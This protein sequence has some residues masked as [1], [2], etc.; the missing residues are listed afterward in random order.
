M[1]GI[2]Q[3]ITLTYDADDAID[4]TQA[5][6]ASQNTLIASLD[7]V[8]KSGVKL[9]KF[10]N[11]VQKTFTALDEQGNKV[12]R[13]FQ[14]LKNNI[15]ALVSETVDKTKQLNK[16]LSLSQTNAGL[17]KTSILAAGISATR[18]GGISLLDNR[19]AG[20][21]ISLAKAAEEGNVDV[22]RLKIIY[23]S[24]SN[25][26]ALNFNAAEA[27]VVKAVNAI[28]K[29]QRKLE[30]EAQRTA[31]VTKAPGT[32][33]SFRSDQNLNAGFK[34]APRERVEKLN[35][36]LA[37]LQGIVAK[38]GISV[39]DLNR[40]YGQLQTGMVIA[41][42][43]SERRVIPALRNV[44]KAHQ[45]LH[46][47]V[48]RFLS[49]IRLSW[50][51][52]GRL[53]A[54]QIFHR[55]I[56][57]IVQEFLL[58][59]TAALKFANS[60][61]LI[62][63]LT[64]EN[65]SSTKQWQAAIRKSSE[66]YGTELLD[67]SAAY[68]EAISNQITGTISATERFVNVSLRLAAVTQST[69]QDSGAIIAGVL[70][71][72]NLDA[73]QAERV[74]AVLFKTIDLGSLNIK[75][76]SQQIG[77]AAPL[78]KILGVTF[79]ELAASIATFTIE[80]RKG[81]AALTLFRN[82][83]LK[84]IKPTE[85]M[86]V[87]LKELGFNSGPAAVKMLG[88]E[89]VI[90]EFAKVLREEGI[91]ELAKYNNELRALEGA[92]SLAGTSFTKYINALR[93]M[94]NATRDFNAA[95]EL[96]FE[97]PLKKLEIEFQRIRNFFIIDLS[98]T[99]LNALART[100]EAIG[101][102][103]SQIRG[104]TQDLS[105]SI[106]VQLPKQI[107]SILSSLFGAEQSFS[108]LRRAI[109]SAT[110]SLIIIKSTLYFLPGV[111]GKI[112]AGILTITNV[113]YRLF[114]FVTD[115]SE[116]IISEFDKI[117]DKIVE[118]RKKAA[119]ANFDLIAAS[120]EKLISDAKSAILNYLQSLE[121]A[122]DKERRIII[123]DAKDVEAFIESS[124]KERANRFRDYLDEIQRRIKANQEAI[125]QSEKELRDIINERES[126]QFKFLQQFRSDSAKFNAIVAR[127]GS[128]RNK[129]LNADP[130]VAKD[131]KQEAN[132][133][134]QE[135]N[136][137]ASKGDIKNRTKLALIERQ[138]LGILNVYEESI[139]RQNALRER[140]I[141][142][143]QT[144][145]R[146]DEQ[147]LIEVRAIIREGLKFKLFDNAGNLE[148]KTPTEAIDK[149]N[150][151]IIKIDTAINDSP[152]GQIGDLVDLRKSLTEDK[153]E[154]GRNIKLQAALVDKI[155]TIFNRKAVG[156]LVPDELVEVFK[157][158]GITGDNIGQLRL[159]AE[160][161]LTGLRDKFRDV[162]DRA[163]DAESKRIELTSRTSGIEAQ[164]L[165][166][167]KNIAS[168]PQKRIAETQLLGIADVK[169]LSDLDS[170]LKLVKETLEKNKGFLNISDDNINTFDTL[171]EKLREALLSTEEAT[172]TKDALQAFLKSVDGLGEFKNAIITAQD[173]SEIA[174][175]NLT[176][177]IYK[178]ID[179]LNNNGVQ[180][181]ASGGY[182]DNIPAR[183]T[184][185]EYVV[186]R[187]AVK[188]YRPQL[189]RMNNMSAPIS[190]YDMGG[191]TVNVTGSS[192]PQITAKAVV[193]EIRRGVR[194]GIFTLET[195]N[196]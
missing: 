123:E 93:E 174:T 184:K 17:L 73:S 146:L 128:I 22:A 92:T 133:L 5:F 101:G 156:E 6:V 56:A 114:N 185:G 35:V 186:N 23:D 144:Q 25:N 129:I 29:A 99:F 193:D 103:A 80:G 188:Y 78:A 102:F 13:T 31:N 120:T 158:F 109:I 132:S 15:D 50:E 94:S 76:I 190:N 58:A 105:N 175:T 122:S 131:L 98:T 108:S 34:T 138:R 37:Q 95:S 4:A 187:D 74:A 82:I 157:K 130:E 177:A 112:A 7:N 182:V 26:I 3:Q 60:L 194:R 107:F 173:R 172:Q 143:L 150:G 135:A 134:I 10:N 68:Y 161:V 84:L 124:L 87:R 167:V 8:A 166:I 2:P 16:E 69:A 71:A 155:T 111:F 54:I 104:L 137:L 40:L 88:F 145:K 148:F 79:E 142:L 141:Q 20:L 191:I 89:G 115:E 55:M 81:D 12:T 57:N 41:A 1:A 119:T 121:A 153:D 61:N 97:Q 21:R 110:E 32:I 66:L 67:T 100:N 77:R 126:G 75:D 90:R 171:A 181:F 52:V 33:S 168:D 45:E 27:E 91:Q 170:R 162:L 140:E 149:I 19:L 151:L 178:L 38:T 152:V 147:R 49:G 154:I 118:Q 113:A 65:E 59:N 164:L 14:V 43:E 46:N 96:I 85:A 53:A 139:K 125:K 86:S 180:G 30:S 47:G 183:L 127:L 163:R 24:L 83:A 116:K 196:A 48:G 189:E 117:N 176:D 28:I 36:A 18:T 42:T 106:F 62:K 44:F 64:L 70:N 159:S 51:S 192:S 39:G 11:V 179:K 63:T 160:D 169:V 195:R 165:A 72:F 136:S 9:D